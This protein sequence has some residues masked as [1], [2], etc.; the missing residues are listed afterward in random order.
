MKC[1]EFSSA[2]A[3]QFFAEVRGEFVLHDRYK[4]FAA[5]HTGFTRVPDHG[6]MKAHSQVLPRHQTPHPM[7]AIEHPCILI[8]A[9]ALAGI[10]TLHAQSKF[11]NTPNRPHARPRPPMAAPRAP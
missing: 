9:V 2:G 5:A 1:E 3:G 11:Q 7:K 6:A 4:S 8:L 10:G